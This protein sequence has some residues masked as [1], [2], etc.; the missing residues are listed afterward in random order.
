MERVAAVKGDRAEGNTKSCARRRLSLFASPRSTPRAAWSMS[1]LLDW[2]EYWQ[3]ALAWCA[4]LD[5]GPL[6]CSL[7][8][9][10]VAASNSGGRTT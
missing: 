2:E 1:L 9:F 6:L 7:L 8:V 4:I 3:T 10:R 5:L